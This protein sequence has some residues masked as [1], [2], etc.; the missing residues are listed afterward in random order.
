MIGSKNVGSILGFAYIDYWRKHNISVLLVKI[1]ARI[2][3]MGLNVKSKITH[4][5]DKLSIG[6]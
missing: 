1:L 5:N 6:N 4:N 3:K 2:Y